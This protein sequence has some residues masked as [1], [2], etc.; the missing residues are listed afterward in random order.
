MAAPCAALECPT[1]QPAGAPGSI[2]ETPAQIAEM[3]QVLAS[4][5]LSNRIPLFVDA[6]RRRHPNVPAGDL[7]NYLV[8]AYCPTVNNLTGL[9]DG[10]KQAKMDA[11][12]SRVAQAAY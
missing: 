1:P 12:A 6:L 8:T 7:V 2:Q 11:F 3:S 5:D 9:S 10:E 4:G